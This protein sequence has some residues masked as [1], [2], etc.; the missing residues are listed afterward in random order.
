MNHLIQIIQILFLKKF[1]FLKE[2]INILS[3][4]IMKG[5]ILLIITLFII[6]RKMIK[7]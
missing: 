1:K 5:V 7:C 6:E 3:Y 2:K 4:I